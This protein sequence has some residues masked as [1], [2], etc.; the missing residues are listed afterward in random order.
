MLKYNHYDFRNVLFTEREIVIFTRLLFY[1]VKYRLPELNF[2]LQSYF[3]EI[4]TFLYNI[5]LKTEINVYR[6]KHIKTMQLSHTY[7]SEVTASVV[8]ILHTS[9]TTQIWYSLHVETLL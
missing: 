6:K 2:N 4:L 1:Y 9:A 5:H 8:N 7:K 3:V